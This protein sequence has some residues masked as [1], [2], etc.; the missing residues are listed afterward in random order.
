MKPVKQPD[1]SEDVVACPNCGSENTEK[2]TIDKNE[3]ELGAK[4]DIQFICNDCGEKFM[5]ALMESVIKKWA[6]KVR[7]D[8]HNDGRSWR[9]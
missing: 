5:P 2:L 4:E 6:K 8:G 3:N 7:F 9:D 1:Y